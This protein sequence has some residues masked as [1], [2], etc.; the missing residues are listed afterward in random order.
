MVTVDTSCTWNTS[1]AS[2]ASEVGATVTGEAVVNICACSVL[3]WIRST[4]VDVVDCKGAS[5]V[6]VAQIT[7]LTVAVQLS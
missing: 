2:W 4:L 6:T 7:G 5:V 1:V 3:A